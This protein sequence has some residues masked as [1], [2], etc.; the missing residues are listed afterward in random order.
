[1]LTCKI[2]FNVYNFLFSTL[3]KIFICLYQLSCWQIRAD[4]T[5]L[6]NKQESDAMKEPSIL[7]QN[8]TTLTENGCGRLSFNARAITTGVHDAISPTSSSAIDL[9]KK[10]LQIPQLRLQLNLN[11]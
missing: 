2:S 1:M 5:E 11:I 3:N 9:I 8:V 4:V 6:R 10:I 7:A